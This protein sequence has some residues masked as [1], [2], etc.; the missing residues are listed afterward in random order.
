MVPSLRALPPTGWGHTVL[1]PSFATAKGLGRWD[2][3]TTIGANLPATGASA[4][5]QM[6]VFNTA[7]DYKIRG[8]IWPMLEQNSTFWSGG[9][10]DGKKEVFLTPGLVL[11]SFPLAERLHLMIAVVC[12]SPQRSSTSTIIAGFSRCAFRSE[13]GSMSGTVRL[14]TDVY[15]RPGWR[16]EAGL[17]D[18]MSLFFEADCIMN[19]LQQFVVG[20]PAA[21]QFVQIVVPD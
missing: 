7:I 20:G 6:I 21:N 2:I 8:K 17:P 15:H 9:T 16:H 10:L 19:K 1:I 3:Q 4:L 18:V 5:G 11:G 13:I 12:R 14:T